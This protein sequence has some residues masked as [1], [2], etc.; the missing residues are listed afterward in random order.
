MVI[1]LIT[2]LYQIKRITCKNVSQFHLTTLLWLTHKNWHLR[3]FY[4]FKINFL[5]HGLLLLLSKVL[6]KESKFG[7]MSLLTVVTSRYLL[8]FEVVIYCSLNCYVVVA[9]FGFLGF[10][11]AVT[12]NGKIEI[13]KKKRKKP[14]S[15]KTGQNNTDILKWLIKLIFWIVRA[16]IIIWIKH[17]I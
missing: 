6:S 2:Y 10:P 13:F 12:I 7:C 1:N 17:S 5:I 4:I 11:F 9:L 15:T 3:V 8:S 16:Q 14:L